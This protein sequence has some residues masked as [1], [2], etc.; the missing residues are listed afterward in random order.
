MSDDAISLRQDKRGRLVE[1]TVLQKALKQL[2]P[3]YSTEYFT[4]F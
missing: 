2:T 1:A 4:L 3:E